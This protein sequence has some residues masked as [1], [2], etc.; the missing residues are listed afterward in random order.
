MVLLGWVERD[1]SEG[2]DPA[3]RDVEK[4]E[5]V[6]QDI[7]KAVQY[8]YQYTFNQCCEYKNLHNLAWI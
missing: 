7:A 1:L 3:N 5:R 2:T 8:K 6:K 4:I